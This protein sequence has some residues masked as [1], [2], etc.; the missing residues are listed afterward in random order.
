MSEKGVI[1]ELLKGWRGGDEEAL[2]AL[3]EAVHNELRRCAG[4]YL[5]RRSGN[6]T[7]QPTALINEAWIRLIAQSEPP[8]CE[9]RSHFFGLAA[10]LMRLVLIDHARARNAAKRGRAVERIN[11]DA[12]DVFSPDRPAD[13]LEVSEALDRLTRQDERKARIIEMRYF[14]G[15]TREEIAEALG[16]SVATIKRDL[17]LGEAWLARFMAHPVVL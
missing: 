1:T 7:L 8:L 2:G 12:I 14:G 15:M 10:R 5:A 17:R 4:R 16:L 6:H 13:I 9:N 11:L 3:T